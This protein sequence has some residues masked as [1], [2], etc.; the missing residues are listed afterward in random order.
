MNSHLKLSYVISVR[1][2]TKWTFCYVLP[3]YFPSAAIE[4]LVNTMYRSEKVS[5]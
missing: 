2:I 3:L 1:C 4:D 5:L